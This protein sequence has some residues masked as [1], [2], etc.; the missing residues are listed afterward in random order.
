MRRMAIFAVVRQ[1]RDPPR[2]GR[3][4]VAAEIRLLAWR[5]P[6]E[7]PTWAP[8]AFM[9]GRWTTVTVVIKTELAQQVRGLP[10]LSG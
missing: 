1:D 7:N 10:E 3:P 5:L 2:P 8:G 6:T 4:T 9:V